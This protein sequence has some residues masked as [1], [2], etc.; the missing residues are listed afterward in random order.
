MFAT[1]AFEP[2]RTVTGHPRARRRPANPHADDM[3]AQ[4]RERVTRDLV[5]TDCGASRAG[6]TRRR[7]LATVLFTDIAGS[8]EWAFRLGDLRWSDL[9]MVHDTI[10]REQL[11]S[12]EGHE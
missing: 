10:V 5:P 7:E 9:L 4:Q 1:M 11:R 12:C 6:A 8:T 2:A 3:S